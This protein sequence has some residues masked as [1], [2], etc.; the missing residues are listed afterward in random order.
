MLMVSSQQFLSLAT[1][2]ATASFGFTPI[3]FLNEGM[4]N[5]FN[6]VEVT[7]NTGDSLQRALKY[8]SKKMQ[9]LL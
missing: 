1:A 7:V 4:I 6:A 8:C 2:L 5:D 9:D 3:S